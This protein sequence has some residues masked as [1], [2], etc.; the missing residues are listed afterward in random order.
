MVKVWSAPHGPIVHLAKAHLE[1]HGI[2]CMI[3]GENLARVA[4]GVPVGD[5]WVELWV[6]DESRVDEALM[7][8]KAIEDE[9]GADA[10][11]WRCPTCG[12]E[13]EPQFTVCW[14]CGTPR[15]AA[16]P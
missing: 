8:L 9:T 12:E 4:G 2:P 7:L 16:A 10:E 5:A 6:T 1:S 3:Q 14:Q 11:P 15:E 13:L